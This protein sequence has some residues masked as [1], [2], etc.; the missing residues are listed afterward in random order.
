M[1]FREWMQIRSSQGTPDWIWFSD[2]SPEEAQRFLEEQAP[3][4]FHQWEIREVAQRGG[5][6]VI[7]L[8]GVPAV[9]LFE[10][11]SLRIFPGE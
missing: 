6:T 1:T 11:E 4:L 3:R 8:K 10:L 5:K 7:T 2:R 9:T